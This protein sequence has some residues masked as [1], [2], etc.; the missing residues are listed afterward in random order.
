MRLVE[1]YKELQSILVE[2]HNQDIDEVEAREQ[3]EELK[4]VAL[5]AG[6]TVV[7]KSDIIKDIQLYEGETSYN[8]YDEDEDNSEENN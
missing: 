6:L 1:F 2:Y 5:D 4:K 8:S 3:I 7:V